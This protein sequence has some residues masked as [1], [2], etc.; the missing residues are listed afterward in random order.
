VAE[1]IKENTILDI[2]ASDFAQYAECIPWSVCDGWID[3][4]GCG[5]SRHDGT[6]FIPYLQQWIEKSPK[7]G[8][9][10]ALCVTS[11]LEAYENPGINLAGAFHAGLY[12]VIQ[13][14]YRRLRSR[15]MDTD[16][17]IH[18][19]ALPSQIATEFFAASDSVE[20]CYRRGER[21]CAQLQEVNGPAL[22]SGVRPISV[23][24]ADHVLWITGG[25]RGLGQ[26]C[27]RHFVRH[28][29]V[30]HL[31]LT[32]REPF[33]PRSEWAKYQEQQDALGAKVRAIL[34]L[35]AE[36]AKV[37]ISSVSLADPQA[38]R[39][40]LEE[41]AATL[42]PI[43]G[44]IHCAGRIDLETAPLIRKNRKTMESV[45]VPK[46]Q[47]LDNLLAC[48]EREPLQ[49]VVLFSSVSAAVPSLAA[50]QIDYAAANA[51]MDYVAQA[52]AAQLPIISIQWPSWSESG[53]GEAKSQAYQQTGLLT[54][55]T[56]EGL[57]LLERV[58]AERPAPVVLPAIVDTGR[59]HPEKLML[60]TIEDGHARTQTPPVAK[61][62]AATGGAAP[63]LKQAAESWLRSMIAAQL[64]MDHEQ[65]ESNRSLLDYGVD[66]VMLVQLPLPV[67]EALG[68]KLPPSILFEC[69]TIGEFSSWLVTNHSGSLSKVVLQPED[70]DAAILNAADQQATTVGI[71]EQ[72]PAAV[73]LHEEPETKSLPQTR[74]AVEQS[75]SSEIAVIGMSCQFP[76]AS[77]LQEYWR[78]LSEGRSALRKIPPHRYAQANGSVAGMLDNT[79]FFDP[80]FF[81]ISD[82]DARAMD[83]QALLVLEESLNALH[84]A[85]YSRH[86]MKGASIGVYIGARSYHR[87]DPV[88]LSRA[89]NPILAVGQNYLAAN[90]ARFLDLHGPAL[91]VDTACSSALVAMHLA[92]QALSSGEVGAALV[93]GVSLLREDALRLFDQRGILSKSPQFHL[94]D[95]R[96]SGTILGEGAGMVVLKPLK[97]AECDGDS[98]YAVIKAVAI[99]NDGRTASASSPNLKAQ[100]E[101]MQAALQKAA[102]R[103]EDISYVCM[104]GS[105]SEVTDLLEL[106]AVQS[107]YRAGAPL[108]CCLGSMKPNIGHPLC[109]E[110]IAS[111]ISVA[112]MLHHGELV[113]FLSG[114]QPMAHYDWKSSPFR[115]NRVPEPWS[116]PRHLAAINCFADG[117]TNAHVIL[118]ASES[119]LSRPALRRPLPPPPLEKVDVRMLDDNRRTEAPPLNGDHP[120]TA[121]FWNWLSPVA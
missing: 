31:L 10:T 111:F 75:Y 76:G 81:L 109:A 52:Y 69:P 67:G 7:A 60:S 72:H 32:G 11:R 27:A 121:N 13:S 61:V 34:E 103:P 36:G 114:E 87:P 56:S 96:A 98:I 42:G 30:K 49:F 3:L 108:P 38:L 26:E 44:I 95:S 16:L 99:N 78:L 14:E 106:K 35:E 74:P 59:W 97:Q 12:R 84:H 46:I 120:K 41:V 47:G 112:L 102:V 20:V 83:P 55:K 104:N 58:L 40:E 54:L 68:E 21:Y 62:K 28:Y 5:E 57:R 25:T 37:R 80:R 64:K 107:V 100:Q 24:P 70:E 66:S 115:F 39:Q 43:G 93:G 110:G 33:P 118:Q 18:D 2:D 88:S 82:A 4:T 53:F 8:M 48:V 9:P 17:T 1:H 105:G 77:N 94:F 6:E 117:G 15:H 101:V 71:D 119:S 79:T 50:G 92:I 51:Y 65:L 73:L 91:V 113:P 63:S 29:G 116:S 19:N 86:E 23:F 45:M 89:L 90:I 22:R 85:G